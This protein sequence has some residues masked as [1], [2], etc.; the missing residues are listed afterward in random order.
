MSSYSEAIFKNFLGK[1]GAMDE[2][3]KPSSS[4]KEEKSQQ[5]SPRPR[6]FSFSGT[7]YMVLDRERSDLLSRDPRDLR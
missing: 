2:K 6:F 5:S 3:K 7:G 4:D 1:G